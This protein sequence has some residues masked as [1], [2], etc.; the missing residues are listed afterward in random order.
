MALIKMTLHVTN[1]EKFMKKF[2]I[3]YLIN[4]EF[5]CDDE[6]EIFSWIQSSLY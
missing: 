6:T 3:D 1:Y 5:A 2:C 4:A